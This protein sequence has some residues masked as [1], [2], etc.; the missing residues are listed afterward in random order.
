MQLDT[1]VKTM[2]DVRR[3]LADIARQMNQTFVSTEQTGTGAAQNIAHSLFQTPRAVFA[4]PSNL[5][6][7]VFVVTYG[8]HTATNCVVTVTLGEKYRVIAI[9]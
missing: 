2:D 6:G 4:V 5:T 7:G 1:N 9:V 8:T 3:A